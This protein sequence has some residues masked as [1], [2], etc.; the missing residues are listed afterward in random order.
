MTPRKLI[1][2]YNEYK[3]EFKYRDRAFMALNQYFGINERTVDSEE[4]V[5]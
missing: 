5:I 1:L 3:Q 2:L 4:E